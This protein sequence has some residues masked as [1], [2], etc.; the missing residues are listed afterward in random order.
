M[1]CTMISWLCNILHASVF[2]AVPVPVS[3]R[4]QIHNEWIQLE[5]W[6]S[7]FKYYTWTKDLLHSA[8]R[9]FWNRGCNSTDFKCKTSNFHFPKGI[10][11]LLPQKEKAHSL[12]EFHPC[13]TLGLLIVPYLL[14]VIGQNHRWLQTKSAKLYLYIYLLCHSLE[15]LIWFLQPTA[16]LMHFLCLSSIL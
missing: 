5:H 1:Q 13:S 4:H 12:K 6:I 3:C 7:V 11:F 2:N 14:W 9:Y 8:S 10:F 15:I 16:S